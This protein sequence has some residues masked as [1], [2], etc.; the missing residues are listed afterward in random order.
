M[1]DL[2]YQ[3]LKIISYFDFLLKIRSPFKVIQTTKKGDLM[4]YNFQTILSLNFNMYNKI[5]VTSYS[6]MMALLLTVERKNCS[7]M[8]RA[9]Q[10]S[11]VLL[12]NFLKNADDN[13]G[14]MKQYLVDEA[15]ELTKKDDSTVLIVDFTQLQKPYAYRIENLSYDRNGCSGRIEKGLSLGAI[16]LAGKNM[17]I[18]LD[19]CIWKQK[20]YCEEGKYKTKNELAKDLIREIVSKDIKF[21][22]ASFDGAFA[23]EDFLKFLDELEIKFVMKIQANRVIVTKDGS[24]N[25]IRKT[26]TLQLLRNERAKSIKASYKGLSLDFVAHKRRCKDNEWETVYLVGNMNI[27][28]KE[29]VKCYVSRSAVEKMFRTIKQSLGV[30]QCQVLSGQKQRSHIFATFMA[31]VFLEQQKIANQKQCPEDIIHLLRSGH[32]AD[33]VEA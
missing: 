18:P 6:Y 16:V 13:T 22:Y 19:F 17:T 30:A 3:C 7:S 4:K 9:T 24:R 23:S 28:A 2:E 32:C 21:K 33:L 31:Y 1:N 20:K 5:K 14:L 26:S 15:R 27:S 25:Q 10:I 11:R 8:S 12:Y 29:Y